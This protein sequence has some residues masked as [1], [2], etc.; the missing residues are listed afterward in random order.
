M[1]FPK[2]KRREVLARALVEGEGKLVYVAHDLGYHRRYLYRL[3]YQYEL[4][5]VANKVRLDRIKR[6]RLQRSISRGLQDG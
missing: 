1:A 3:I 4:W 2:S 6:E 5:P